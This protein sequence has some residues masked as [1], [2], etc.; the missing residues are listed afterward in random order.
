MPLIYKEDLREEFNLLV[1]DLNESEEQLKKKLSPN[2]IDLKKL[3][4]FTH[5]LKRKYFLVTIIILKYFNIKSKQFKKDNN[6]APYLINTDKFI[7]ITNK[8][9][10]IAVVVSNFSVG[11]DCEFYNK[12]II[13]IKEKFIHN[14]EK[15]WLPIN[16][17]IKY[18][19]QLW[20]IKESIYKAYSG[21]NLRYTENIF[22]DPFEIT[23]TYGFGNTV[24]DN[25]IKRVKLYFR[26][27]KKYS[28]TIAL[29][30]NLVKK[31]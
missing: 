18:L 1:W 9:N 3:T 2:N 19:T 5:P 10:I 13:P 16:N 21:L 11:V 28:L 24:I 25:K 14:Y 27:S 17:Q 4:S 23:K 12:K 31:K 20:T 29:N 6:G 15:E 8:Y 30:K 7:S 26:N 22:S